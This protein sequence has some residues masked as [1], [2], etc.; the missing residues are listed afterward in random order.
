MPSR[1]TIEL[2]RENGVDLANLPWQ[3]AEAR[4]FSHDLLRLAL[5]YG[6]PCSTG[7]VL[8]AI[9]VVDLG[10]SDELRLLNHQS[11]GAHTELRGQDMFMERLIP[12]WTEHGEE[13][14]RKITQ[15]MERAAREADDDLA[16]QMAAA[17]KPE[18]EN[19]WS[20]LGGELP[21]PI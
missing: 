19:L 12:G 20:R 21:D 5:R 3:P 2:A 14:E 6:G 11:S 9:D 16:E 10:R 8:S 15:S 4:S 13:L 7:I 1:G 17:P 18:L